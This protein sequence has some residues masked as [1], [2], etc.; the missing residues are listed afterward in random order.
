MAIETTRDFHWEDVQNAHHLLRFQGKANKA[1]PLYQRCLQVNIEHLYQDYRSYVTED[2]TDQFSLN[3]YC[4]YLIE[5]FH[6]RRGL[7][8]QFMKLATPLFEPQIFNTLP[9]AHQSSFVVASGWARARQRG[10]H[11]ATDRV[12]DEQLQYLEFVPQHSTMAGL[13]HIFLA[14]LAQ[15]QRDAQAAHNHLES[16]LEIFTLENEPFYYLL[17]RE[18]R[19]STSYLLRTTSSGIYRAIDEY[20]EVQKLSQKMN[21]G[22]DIR[23]QNYNMGWAMAEC[24]EI[25]PTDSLNTFLEGRLRVSQLEYGA[26]EV[27]MYNYGISFAYILLGQFDE[28]YELLRDAVLIFC[29]QSTIMLVLCLHHQAIILQKKGDIVTARERAYASL[30]LLH[31]AYDITQLY[32]LHRR[33]TK[34]HRKPLVLHRFFYHLLQTY[35]LKLQTG[36]PLFPF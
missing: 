7:W 29:D 24:S 30:H 21:N 2:E 16:A 18:F 27:A 13:H 35:R 14:Y 23:E 1:V 25:A 31:N 8:P 11:Q 36:K 12:R 34:L 32:N 10:N 19:A 6:V 20:K 4:H 28:A 15:Q 17:A 9:L 26:Y 33:L 3:W 22:L 5:Y